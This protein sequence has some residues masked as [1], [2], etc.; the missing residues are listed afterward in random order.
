MKT[1]SVPET[2]RQEG[3]AVGD[4]WICLCGNRP[5]LQGFF[6]CDAKGRAEPEPDEWILF[7]CDRCGRI[8]DAETLEVVGLASERE[9]WPE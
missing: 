1:Q 3:P 6:P 2:I 7:V 5:D 8:I 4:A 9:R